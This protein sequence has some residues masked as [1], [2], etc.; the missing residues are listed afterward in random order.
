M[1]EKVVYLPFTIETETEITDRQAQ[2]LANKARWMFVC[3]DYSE[4]K[5]KQNKLLSL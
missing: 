3:G 5:L 2:I 4:R 1:A